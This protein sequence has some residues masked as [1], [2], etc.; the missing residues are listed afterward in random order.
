M[1]I[2]ALI[3]ILL[4]Q[5]IILLASKFYLKVLVLEMVR[6]LSGLLMQMEFILLIQVGLQMHKQYLMAMKIL[7]SR[8]LIMMD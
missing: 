3:G 8:T 1:M 5:R 6:I 2:L 7:L 4:Q